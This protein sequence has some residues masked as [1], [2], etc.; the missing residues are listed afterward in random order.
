M[1]NSCLGLGFKI[2]SNIKKIIKIFKTY[3]SVEINIMLH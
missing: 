3:V 2:N 1:L